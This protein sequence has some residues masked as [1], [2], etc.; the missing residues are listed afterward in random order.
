MSLHIE[1]KSMGCAALSN[2]LAKKLAGSGAGLRVIF[3]SS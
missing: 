3:H 2:L 1:I